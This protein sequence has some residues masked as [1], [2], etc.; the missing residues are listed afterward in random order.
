MN[1]AFLSSP[2]AP[3]FSPTLEKVGE[4][5]HPTVNA[6]D[7][8]G[9]CIESKPGAVPQQ[10]LRSRYRLRHA[11]E[12]VGNLRRLC[13]DR[14]AEDNGL[15]QRVRPEGPGRVDRRQVPY[16]TQARYRRSSICDRDF[17]LLSCQSRQSPVPSGA[18]SPR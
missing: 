18:R 7:T 13:D 4:M 1:P 17:S 11:G 5:L 3:E 10:S 6:A 12:S 2:F 14:T 15:R 9:T 8:R 16:T